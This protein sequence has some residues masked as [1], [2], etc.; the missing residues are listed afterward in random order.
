VALLRRTE[1]IV[2][3]T[4]SS[5]FFIDAP[6]LPPFNGLERACGVPAQPGIEI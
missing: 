2:V 1:A 4:T 6:C 5:S 3:R